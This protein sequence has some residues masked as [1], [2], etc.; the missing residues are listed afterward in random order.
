MDTEKKK[1]RWENGK[2]KKC[3]LSLQVSVEMCSSTEHTE[4]RFNLNCWQLQ[5][6]I[7]KMLL[8][9]IWWAYIQ[10]DNGIVHQKFFALRLAFFSFSFVFSPCPCLHLSISLPL[11][12]SYVCPLYIQKHWNLGICMLTSAVIPFTRLSG[13]N[14]LWNT[15]YCLHPF[16]LLRWVNRGAHPTNEEKNTHTQP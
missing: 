7:L 14:Y 15:N 10:K 12:G 6:G 4:N 13:V 3:A 8:D 16:L 1:N 2:R 9:V 11:F 5:K